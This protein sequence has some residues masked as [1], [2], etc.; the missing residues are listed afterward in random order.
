MVKRPE[1]M[2][3]NFERLFNSGDLD[4]LVA[5]YEKDALFVDGE[6]KEHRGL[7][8]IRGVLTGFLTG[9]PSI[10]LRGV[11]C[12]TMGDLA[13]GRVAWTLTGKD[14]AGQRTEVGGVSSE[15]MRRQSDGS[16]KFAIDLPVGG[17]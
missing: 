3:A 15:L 11:Y 4:G 16:W 9:R 13:L 12:R 17:A 6:G 8:A 7:A 2:P 5:L 1:D 10:A 14:A